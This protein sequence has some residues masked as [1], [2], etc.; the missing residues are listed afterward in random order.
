MKNIEQDVQNNHSHEALI[1]YSI[2]L[3]EFVVVLGLNVG[4]LQSD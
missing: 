2:S 1:N 4:I 3:F